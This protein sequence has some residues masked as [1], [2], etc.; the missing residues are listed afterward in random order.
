MVK[1]YLTP[2]QTTGN[3]GIK[4]PER[5]RLIVIESRW[6]RSSLQTAHQFMH[7]LQDEILE[8]EYTVTG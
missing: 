6:S 2:M 1:E 8:V 3:P 5:K 4:L 7:H